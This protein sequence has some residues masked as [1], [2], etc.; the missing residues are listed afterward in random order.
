MT[1]AVCR[2]NCTEQGNYPYFEMK[3]SS[4][5]ILVHVYISEISKSCRLLQNFNGVIVLYDKNACIIFRF[6]PIALPITWIFNKLI[7][8]LIIN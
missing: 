7:G 8:Y 3:S 2:S 6:V 4:L 5:N 1:L